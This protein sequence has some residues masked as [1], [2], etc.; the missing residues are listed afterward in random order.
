MCGQE[1][2]QL[3][4]CVDRTTYRQSRMSKDEIQGPLNLADIF[5]FQLHVK[6]L[7]LSHF[8]F[9]FDRQTTRPTDQ[10]GDHRSS[11][12]ELKK[13]SDWY[14]SVVYLQKID[15]LGNNMWPRQNYTRSL[16]TDFSHTCSRCK[17]YFANTTNIWHLLLC[18]L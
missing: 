15:M 6:F 17:L 11:S 13:V 16:C 8:K 7:C 4:T 10:K 9:F 14:W 1:Y 5:R 12:L 18:R 2:V 3:R